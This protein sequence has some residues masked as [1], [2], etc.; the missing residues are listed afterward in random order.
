M[1]VAREVLGTDDEAFLRVAEE[2]SA[3]DERFSDVLRELRR[4]HVARVVP[5]APPGV[6]R[7]AKIPAWYLT[8]GPKLALTRAR[9]EE[10]T[11]RLAELT[12]ALSRVHPAL[13]ALA[14]VDDATV[15]GLARFVVDVYQL[16]S[17]ELVSAS[18]DVALAS[19]V[20]VFLLRR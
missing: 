8:R 9:D 12:R 17:A 11:T 5:E 10:R 15:R 4:T 1:D 19:A 7:D 3:T 18:A 16:R 13:G 2:A 20:S 14:H 6:L